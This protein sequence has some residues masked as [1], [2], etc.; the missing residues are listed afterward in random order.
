MAPSRLVRRAS[1]ETPMQK[2]QQPI[3]PKPTFTTPL[4]PTDDILRVHH[5]MLEDWILESLV[6]DQLNCLQM[7]C[8]QG[9]LVRVLAAEQDLGMVPTELKVLFSQ[10]RRQRQNWLLIDACPHS[11]ASTQL[12]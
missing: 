9:H 8:A 12:M 3:G 4:P 1:H 2:Q 7:P 10:A 11:A 5:G 6:N